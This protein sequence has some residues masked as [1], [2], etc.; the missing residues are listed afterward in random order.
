MS[1]LEITFIII[2]GTFLTIVSYIVHVGIVV[3]NLQKEVEALLDFSIAVSKY[4]DA[5]KERNK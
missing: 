2:I 3:N 5:Q 4:I 1:S